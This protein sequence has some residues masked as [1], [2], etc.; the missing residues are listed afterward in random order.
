MPAQSPVTPRVNKIGSTNSQRK[1][2]LSRPYQV[3]ISRI[4]NAPITLSWM[5]N[6]SRNGVSCSNAIAS[7]P[8]LHVLANAG[9]QQCENA[10]GKQPQ[11]QN[12]HDRTE[13]ARFD[14][15]I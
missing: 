1:P 11:Q 8:L 2:R 12:D 14:R 3:T 9:H 10:P 15:D 6:D 5:R 7:T 4:S 13:A